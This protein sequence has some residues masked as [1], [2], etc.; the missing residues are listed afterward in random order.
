MTKMKDSRF[1]TAPSCSVVEITSENVLCTSN[2]SN[3][4]WKGDTDTPDN[5]YGSYD[6][7]SY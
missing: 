3:Y 7:G 4:N 2:F 6:N 1:Y 5:E